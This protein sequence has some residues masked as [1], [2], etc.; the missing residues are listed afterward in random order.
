MDITI[1]N[2]KVTIEQLCEV[3]NNARHM[4]DGEYSKCVELAVSRNKRYRQLSK[5]DDSISQ[6]TEGGTV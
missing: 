1:K 4:D 5:L 6:F 3:L 2:R